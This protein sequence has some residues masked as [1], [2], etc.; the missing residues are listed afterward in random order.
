[1]NEGVLLYVT[2]DTAN[3][4]CNQIEITSPSGTKSILLQ[5]ASGFRNAKLAN[6]R[7]ASNAFY[8]ESVNGTWRATYHNLCSSGSTVLKTTYMQSFIV[9]GH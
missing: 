2:F 4:S 9:V 5:G 1:V 7:F 8:G 3:V 6:T